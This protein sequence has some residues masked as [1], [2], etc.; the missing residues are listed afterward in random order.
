[1]L[2]TKIDIKL[3]DISILRTFSERTFLMFTPKIDASQ[4][5]LKP[6]LIKAFKQRCF[7]KQ[8]ILKANSLPSTPVTA[9][10]QHESSCSHC[11]DPPANRLSNIFRWRGFIRFLISIEEWKF[12]QILSQ[13][14]FPFLSSHSAQA[15]QI[16]F[17]GIFDFFFFSFYFLTLTQSSKLNSKVYIAPNTV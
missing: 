4:S 15:A 8:R 16:P 12:S 14:L 13:L 17:N 3:R 1:M 2:L 5:N 9:Q 6:H 10:P 11:T 7:I